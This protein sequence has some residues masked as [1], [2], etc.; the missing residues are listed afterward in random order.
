MGHQGRV[1]PSLLGMD[2][3]ACG[4]PAGTLRGACGE[5]A[6]GLAGLGRVTAQRGL[7]KAGLRK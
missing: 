2:R 6:E 5:P 4:E 7:C 3:R 1:F